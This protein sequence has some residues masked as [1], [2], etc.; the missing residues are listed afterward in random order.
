MLILT[1]SSFV[2]GV[3]VCSIPLL[4]VNST[5]RGVKTVVPENKLQLFDAFDSTLPL[6]MPGS[7]YYTHMTYSKLTVY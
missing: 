4:L 6:I 7:S 1:L 3:H 5:S 2:S